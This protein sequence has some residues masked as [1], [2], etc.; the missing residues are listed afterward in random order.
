MGFGRYIAEKPMRLIP[1]FAVPAGLSLLV[2]QSCEGT[3][4]TIFF[5]LG[6]VFLLGC[7]VSFFFVKTAGGR[8]K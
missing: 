5:T 1:V 7:V 6:M 8:R 2:S 3:C 4:S